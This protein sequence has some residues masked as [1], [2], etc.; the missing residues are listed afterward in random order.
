MLSFTACSEKSQPADPAAPQVEKAI[1]INATDVEIYF[2]DGYTGTDRPDVTQFVIKD[3]KGDRVE[4]S[5]GYGYGGGVFFDNMLTLRLAESF[6]EDDT[7]QKLKLTY[8]GKKYDIPYD[9]YYKYSTVADCGVTIKGGR[10]LI[11]PDKTLARAAEMGL[12]PKGD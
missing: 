3:N 9:A 12:T 8:N 6:A 11:Q 2:A 5:Q 10:T 7:A 1:R 4:L